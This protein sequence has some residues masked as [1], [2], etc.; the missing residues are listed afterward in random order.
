MGEGPVGQQPDRARH[1]AAA[2]ETRHQRVAHHGL[3]ERRD[4]PRQLQV[5]GELAGGRVLDRQLDPLPRQ[6][7]VAGAPAALLVV[8]QRAERPHAELGD[9]RLGHHP[10]EVRGVPLVHR[11][12]PHHAVAQLAALEERQVGLH[13]LARVPGEPGEHHMIHP[14]PVPQR[15]GVP[16]A[17]LLAESG[18]VR[19]PQAG[20]VRHLGRQLHP[21]HAPV[22]Q[23]LGQPARHRPGHALATRP[24]RHQIAELD[25]APRDGALVPMEPM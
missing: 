5:A 22:E 11:R 25:R 14:L 8:L 18:L 13:R 24:R 4:D 6:P 9:A 21:L 7:E 10:V 23:P 1:E 3:P 15:L 12:Q 2:A 20:Q 16:P 17:P 19:D